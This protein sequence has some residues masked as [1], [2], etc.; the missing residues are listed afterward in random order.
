ML[1]CRFNL[2]AVVP[3]RRIAITHKLKMLKTNKAIVTAALEKLLATTTT[4]TS[5]PSDLELSKSSS[6][7]PKNVDEATVKSELVKTENS[8][9]IVHVDCDI[10]NDEDSKSKESKPDV[11]LK[12]LSINNDENEEAVK[13]GILRS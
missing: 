3:D 7:S 2:M 10:L 8:I 4:T 1:V 9:E 5:K 6:E 12:N 13:V 11:D